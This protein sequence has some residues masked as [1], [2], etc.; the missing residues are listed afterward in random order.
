MLQQ[1]PKY[2]KSVFGLFIWDQIF[3]IGSKRNHLNHKIRLLYYLYF[4]LLIYM[5][6]LFFLFISVQIL[7]PLHSLSLSQ[8]FFITLPTFPSQFLSVS[9]QSLCFAS[10]NVS[11]SFSIS[12]ALSFSCKFSH[13]TDSN[14]LCVKMYWTAVKFFSLNN[15][16][17]LWTFVFHF[18]WAILALYC[19]FLLPIP[20]DYM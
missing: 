2:E 7:P 9:S 8:S 20:G 11:L 6:N 19:L 3:I 16:P 14:D 13:F 18:F 12:L 5:L 1:S 15:K 10:L 4:S 17:C